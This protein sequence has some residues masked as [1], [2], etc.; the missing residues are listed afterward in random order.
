MTNTQ[1][2]EDFH[3]GFTFM[4]N[5]ERNILIATMKKWSIDLDQ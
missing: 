1:F 3:S 4:F 5:I 2:D